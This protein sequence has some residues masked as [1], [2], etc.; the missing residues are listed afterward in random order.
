[1]SVQ[2]QIYA[3]GMKSAF[4]RSLLCHSFP[5]FII[6]LF[7]FKLKVLNMFCFQ[8]VLSKSKTCL[9]IGFQDR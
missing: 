2:I 3:V 5:S 8:I 4:H 9:K 1:M 7:E 6:L